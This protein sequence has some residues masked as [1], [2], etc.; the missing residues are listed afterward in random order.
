M[1]PLL[2][3]KTVASMNNVW[4]PPTSQGFDVK[5][6]KCL[7]SESDVCT[8]QR[9][10]PHL[11]HVI[12]RPAGHHRV[13]GQNQNA[14]EHSHPAHQYPKPAAAMLLH[15]NS[16]TV[17]RTITPL[18]TDNDLSHQNRQTNQHDADE[19]NQHKRSATVLASKVREFPDI[20]QSNGRTRRRKNKQPPIRPHPMGG[21]VVVRHFS[22]PLTWRSL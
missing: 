19:I 6:L 8:L 10:C 11:D 13:V 9:T 3:M 21:H 20:P 4:H 14:S 22:I 12:D 7:V 2:M 17:D 15:K 5:S 16:Q 1:T 18:P